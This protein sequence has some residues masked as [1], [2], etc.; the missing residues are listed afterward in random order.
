MMRSSRRV[1]A[2]L[3]ILSGA[4]AHAQRLAAPPDT[5]ASPSVDLLTLAE[6]AVVVS[7]SANPLAALS[8]IDGD[9][10]SRWTNGSPRATAP[11]VFVFELRAPTR[12]THVG[13]DNAGPRP[14][15]VLGGSARTLLVEGS[16]ESAERGFVTLGT[17]DAAQDGETL[18]DVRDATPMRWLRFTVRASHSDA[19]RSTYFDEVI[20]RGAQAPPAADE[21]FTG[22]FETA[23]RAFVELKQS[24]STIMGCFVEQAGNAFGEI[25]GEV[26]DGVA[27]LRWRRT[28]VEGVGGVALLVIDSGGRLSG[29]RY[30]SR[31]RSLWSGPRAAAGT[32]TPCSRAT[33][34]R[35]PIADALTRTGEARVYGILFDFDAATLRAQSDTALRQLLAALEA[36]PTLRVTIEG[37]TDDVG[38]DA[39]NLAL[40]ER[41]AQAVVAWLVQHGIGAARLVAVGRGE[42]EPIADN[43]TA[44]GRALN[45][46]VEV[47]RL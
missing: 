30:R 37:H 19:A 41:R 26:V 22:V 12:L 24:G 44:D 9:P 43:A 36:T 46:R 39:Y 15:G 3:V 1:L 47:T 31:S 34:P 33:P 8:L 20:A 10:D 42:I 35:N 4:T 17:F 40:S 18:I 32:T 28:G 21:R 13:I 2:L 25:E 11:F 38:A 23:P 5:P 14:S 45:R 29:V 6:G 16:A 27:R 7:A